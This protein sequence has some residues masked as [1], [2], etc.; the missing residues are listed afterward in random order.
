MIINISKN[1]VVAKNFS[2]KIGF[3]KIK[4]LIGSKTKKTIVFKTRFG[5][6]TFFLKN[7]IDVIVLDK[8][9]KAVIIKR[10]LK[11]N[12]I[13]FWNIKYDSVIELPQESIDKSKT[14]IGDLLK[15]TS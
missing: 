7:S 14:E 4:G 13:F 10:S 9:K 2:I 12:R 8:N 5:I 3:G 15:I 6:H 11:P 1:T